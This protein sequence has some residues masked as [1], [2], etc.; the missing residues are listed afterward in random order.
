MKNDYIP[1]VFLGLI[2]FSVAGY[3]A[4]NVLLPKKNLQYEFM[5]VFVIASAG[6]VIGSIA[7][8]SLSLKLGDA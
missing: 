2:G 4:S 3:V 7:G 6:L 1:M 5:K 8:Y